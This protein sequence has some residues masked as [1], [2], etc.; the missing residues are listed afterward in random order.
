MTTNPFFADAAAKAA[1]DAVAALCN[2]GFIKVYTGTQPADSNT[3]ISGNT[4]LGTFSF[5]STAFAASSA[6]GTA[7]DQSRHGHRQLDLRRHRR[8]HRNGG[9]VPGPQ[10]RRHDRRVRRNLRSQRRGH[11]H[12]RRHYHFRRGHGRRQS[13]ALRSGVTSHGVTE[14]GGR[15]V[16]PLVLPRSAR[17]LLQLFNLLATLARLPAVSRARKHVQQETCSRQK[18]QH[19]A[20][21]QQAQSARPRQAGLWS[22]VT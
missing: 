21:P 13:R 12:D 5:G 4:L 10:D 8:Q 6:S 1:C 18:S 15:D 22:P 9:V 19:G 7:T 20:Q 11:D 17:L 16:P 3:A 2:S 14:G